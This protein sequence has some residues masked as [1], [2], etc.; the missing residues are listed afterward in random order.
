MFLLSFSSIVASNV[1]SEVVSFFKFK[2]QTVFEYFYKVF[3]GKEY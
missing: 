2:F 1:I 3:I